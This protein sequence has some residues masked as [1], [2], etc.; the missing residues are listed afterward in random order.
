MGSRKL[1]GSSP[2]LV[3]EVAVPYEE[4]EVLLEPK[5]L[6]SVLPKA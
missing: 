3:A 6:E 5:K 4:V 1:R 2:L